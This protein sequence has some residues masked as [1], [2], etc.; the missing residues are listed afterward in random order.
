MT[1]LVRTARGEIVDFDLIKIKQQLVDSPAPT[2][3]KARENF[4]EKRLKRRLIRN[5]TVPKVAPVEPVET[6]QEEEQ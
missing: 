5:K 6:D 2:E 1:K 3:V 4:V